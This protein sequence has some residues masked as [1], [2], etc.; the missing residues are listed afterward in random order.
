MIRIR[1]DKSGF[2]Y[3]DRSIEG[4]ADKSWYRG[5]HCNFMPHKKN[6]SEPDAIEKYFLD[7]WLP[8]EAFIG[9]NSKILAFG[10]CFAANISKYLKNKG[11]NLIEGTDKGLI[12]F[13][14]G[15]NNTFAL[16]QLFEWIYLD[17]GFAEENWHT[18]KK[19]VI[20]RNK[21]LKNKTK[22]AFSRANV[23]IITLGLNEVWYNKVTSDVFWRAI[24]LEHFNTNIHGFRTGT[25]LENISNLQSV[26][27][28]L[29]ENN[30][31]AKVIFTL[32]PVSLVATFRPVSCVTANMASKA[33]LRAALDEFL[34]ANSVYQNSK[35][36]YWPS[37]EIVKEY[38]ADAYCDDNRHI[39]QDSVRLI[40]EKFEHFYTK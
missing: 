23:F 31:N 40:M 3:V 28:L 37:Y 27:D 25:V 2:N 19:E 13:S 6:L 9:K 17:R 5:E 34:L 12:N 14:A 22:K 35:L 10:S 39:K 26:Y 24:P 29:I 8:E 36:Y 18:K 38:F 4:H 33:S 30:P 32:S 7:G 16:R 11:Y 20:Q 21:A 15:V 1:N